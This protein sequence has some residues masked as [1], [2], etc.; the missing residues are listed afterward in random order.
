MIPTWGLSGAAMATMIANWIALCSLFFV[1]GRNGWQ[2][3]KATIALCLLPLTLVLGGW[4]GLLAAIVLMVAANQGYGPSEDERG[5]LVSVKQ[6][7]A[8]KLGRSQS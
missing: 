5:Y 7:L 6:K 1:S 3:S 2:P 4:L 8:A